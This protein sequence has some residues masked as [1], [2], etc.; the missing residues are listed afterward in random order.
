MS[1]IANNLSVKLNLWGSLQAPGSPIGVG[2]VE[3]P[4]Q[5]EC[6]VPFTGVSTLGSVGPEA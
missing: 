1:I 2:R 5:V 6:S 3:G 4:I